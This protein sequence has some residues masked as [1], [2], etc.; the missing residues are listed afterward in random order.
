[1]GAVSC[2]LWEKKIFLL[3]QKFDVNK[4]NCILNL[5]ADTISK[6]VL[7]VFTKN[8]LLKHLNMAPAIPKNTVKGVEENEQK[9]FVI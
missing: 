1:M 9:E 7:T 2:F 6:T 3:N 8:K 5:T 4:A